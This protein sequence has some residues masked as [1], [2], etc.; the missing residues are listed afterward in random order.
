MSAARL[1]SS[2]SQKSRLLGSGSGSVVA[3]IAG[4]AVEAAG[5]VLEVV[6]CANALSV[7]PMNASRVTN[8]RVFIW[9]SSFLSGNPLG[10][11]QS[12]TSGWGMPAIVA[13]NRAVGREEICASG[14]TRLQSI[15]TLPAD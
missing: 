11:E 4:D 1:G 9:S 2:P 14:L 3:D 10:T 8:G 12:T 5:G 13:P 7:S 15:A 6:C